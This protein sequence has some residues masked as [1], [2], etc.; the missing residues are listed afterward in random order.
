MNL[1]KMWPEDAITLANIMVSKRCMY[2][3]T[4]SSTVDAGCKTSVML[5]SESGDK[6]EIMREDVCVVRFEIKSAREF[7]SIPLKIHILSIIWS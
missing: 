7:E 3:F 5:Q 1:A 6:K 2:S 4:I